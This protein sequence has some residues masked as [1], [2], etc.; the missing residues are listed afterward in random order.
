LT[1]LL[2]SW[3]YRSTQAR[4]QARSEPLSATAAATATAAPAAFPPAAE[5][6]CCLTFVIAWHGH[7]RYTSPELNAATTK[8][9][10]N[11]RKNGKILG[12]F[13]FGTDRVKEFMDKGFTFISVGNGALQQNP[14]RSGWSSSS[15][16]HTAAGAT[17]QQTP[18]SSSTAAA[19]T[20][21]G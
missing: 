18:R 9:I 4:K 17:Q 20:C 15:S 19:S 10:Y 13:L 3:F 6:V 1:T 8:L 14:T 5:S 16:C 7:R 21:L 12:L 11:A 2:C